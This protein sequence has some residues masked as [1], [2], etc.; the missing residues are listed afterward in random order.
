M[1]F[2]PGSFSAG[3][4]SSW[5]SLPSELKKSLT[6]GVGQVSS[7]LYRRRCS[8]AVHQRSRRNSSDCVKHRY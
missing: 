2:G 5:N 6:V 1:G 3:G 4:P 7:R 8:Y